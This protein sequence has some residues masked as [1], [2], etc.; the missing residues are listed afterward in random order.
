MGKRGNERREKTSFG[1]GVFLSGAGS[2]LAGAVLLGATL[3]YIGFAGFHFWQSRE[4]CQCANVGLVD[5]ETVGV[6]RV[7]RSDLQ[8]GSVRGT[9]GGAL[10]GL[11]AGLA[12]WALSARRLRR[13]EILASETGEEAPTASETGAEAPTATETGAEAPSASA[14]PLLPRGGRPRVSDSVRRA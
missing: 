14:N 8:T 6:E 12:A 3:G 9:V 4:M 2:V 7:S 1:P 13:M 10:V 11:A 5:D